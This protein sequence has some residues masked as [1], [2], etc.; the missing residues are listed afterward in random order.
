MRAKNEQHPGMGQLPK[1][2]SMESLARVAQGTGCKRS[3][4]LQP[5]FFA[6]AAEADIGRGGIAVDDAA[7]FLALRIEDVDSARAA[8]IDVAGRIHF[9]AVGIA[10]LAAAEVGE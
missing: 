2:Q 7:E 8:G 1:T 6:G 9:H 3:A 10:G 4:N 5:C